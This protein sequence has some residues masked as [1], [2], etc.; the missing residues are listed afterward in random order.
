MLETKRI[1]P[2]KIY[3]DQDKNDTCFQPIPF[4]KSGKTV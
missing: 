1:P 2:N 4:I 3:T